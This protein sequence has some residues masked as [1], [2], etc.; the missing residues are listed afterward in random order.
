MR[1]LL[2]LV[3]VLGLGASSAAQIL[4][5]NCTCVG[6]HEYWQWSMYGSHY[7]VGH[8]STDADCEVMTGGSKCRVVGTITLQTYDWTTLN[9][10][11]TSAHWG[12]PDHDVTSS[13]NP[14]TNYEFEH[15]DDTSAQ[16]YCDAYDGVLSW[17]EIIGYDTIYQNPLGIKGGTLWLCDAD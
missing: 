2:T 3:A 7:Q 12:M 15:P 17:I 14:G 16:A 9:F 5:P 10:T 4:P 13:T 1:G 6:P 8:A 11:L